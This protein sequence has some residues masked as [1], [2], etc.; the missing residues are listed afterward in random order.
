MKVVGIIKTR[1]IGEPGS[2]AYEMYNKPKPAVGEIA[3]HEE[4]MKIAKL[5]VEQGSI[6]VVEYYGPNDKK[7]KNK[8]DE[9]VFETIAIRKL[10]NDER[11]YR[12]KMGERVRPY[13][14]KYRRVA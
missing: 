14:I 11:A 3:T 8:L 9:M 5:F 1:E 7:W 4:R 2:E 10:S 13:E 12:E 6:G